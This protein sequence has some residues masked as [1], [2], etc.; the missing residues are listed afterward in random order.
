MTN[1]KK[2]RWRWFWAAA[3]GIMVFLTTFYVLRPYR[4]P[5]PIFRKVVARGSTPHSGTWEAKFEVKSTIP[6]FR[7]QTNL[8]GHAADLRIDLERE[9]GFQ[10]LHG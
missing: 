8:R 9:N 5:D 2:M 1:H 4:I 3:C 6:R 10:F 7:V